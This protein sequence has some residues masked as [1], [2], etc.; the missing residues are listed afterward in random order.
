MGGNRGEYNNVPER[1][2]ERYLP[3]AN[4]SG[5]IYGKKA[6][7]GSTVPRRDAFCSEKGPRG[8]SES[9]VGRRPPPSPLL[10]SGRG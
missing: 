5:V 3:T 1:L 8:A 10:R 6:V 4:D 2:R 9:V 7:A